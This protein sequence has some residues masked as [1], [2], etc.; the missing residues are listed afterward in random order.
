M[1]SDAEF[2]AELE[3]KVAQQLKSQRVGYLL[4][5]GSSYLNGAGYPL[6]FQLWDRIKGRIADDAKRA[7]IQAKLD[8]GANGIEHALDLLDDNGPADTLYRQIV[9]TALAEEFMP[10][11]PPLDLHGEF[12]R[13]IAQR[14]NPCVKVFSL[15]YD[16]L[17]ERAAAASRV[18]V[19]DG[20]LGS[21]QCYFDPVVFEER[22]GRIRGTHKSR[23]FEETVKP[24]HLLKLHGSLGWHECATNG[25]RRCPFDAAP[26][27]TAKRLMVPPQRRKAADTANPPYAALWSTFRGC[28]SQNAAPIN[29][30]VCIGYGFADEHVNTLI[31]SALAR[32][33]F[34]VLIFTKGLSAAAW[35]RWSVKTNVYVVTETQ[36]SIKGQT[37]PGH[38][39]LWSF[40]RLAKEV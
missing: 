22:I 16:P 14:A 8:A 29:R 6:A 10:M 39:D 15:N 35:S 26:P 33:D 21:D 36:C 25:V 12:V 2:I 7:E 23:Q 9:T 28:L 34:T 11:D 17:I 38:A 37:G 5:A 3:K 27:A 31:E 24:L 4:G 40:E 32:T 19:I 13:R 18:R 20:F 30:L 1:L